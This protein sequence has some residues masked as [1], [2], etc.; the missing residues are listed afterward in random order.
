M[1]SLTTSLLG[2]SSLSA[3]MIHWQTGQ[4]IRIYRLD[5]NMGQ[6]DSTESAIFTYLPGT[7]DYTSIGYVYLQAQW[8]ATYRHVTEFDSAGRLLNLWQQWDSAGIWRPYDS[9]HYTYD[10]HG[11][12]TSYLWLTQYFGNND[13]VTA[14]RTAITYGLGNLPVE[15]A[16]E[17]WT[18]FSGWG[19]DET[20]QYHYNG[21][22]EQDTM[23]LIY[24]NISLIPRE[25][26]IFDGWHDFSQRL[27]DSITVYETGALP[28][29]FLSIKTTYNGNTPAQYRNWQWV[30]GSL[31]SRRFLNLD[32]NGYYEL[33]ST[34]Y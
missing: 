5:Y 16:R 29:T 1:P 32:A 22:M 27:T 12:E 9:K 3:N 23:W 18:S 14:R 17:H 30:N 26:H 4:P 11:I 24:P 15:A 6:W 31:Q 21:L 19:P 7:T 2:K 13:T 8:Q 28:G 25:T 20:R 34:H 33:D 10:V